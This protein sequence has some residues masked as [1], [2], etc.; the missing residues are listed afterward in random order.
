MDVDGLNPRD[1]NGGI[2][3]A[4]SRADAAM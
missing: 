1:Y 4:V 2:A 3:A